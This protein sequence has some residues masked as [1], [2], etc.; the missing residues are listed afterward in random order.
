MGRLLLVSNVIKYINTDTSQRHLF[1]V[2]GTGRLVTVNA[3][4]LNATW[5]APTI[6]TSQTAAPGS[7]ALAACWSFGNIYGMR[8]F[9]GLQ[10]GS[11]SEYMWDFTLN[12]TWAPSET[13]AQADPSS[14]VA[15]TMSGNAT[16]NFVNLYMRDSTTGNLMHKYYDNSTRS[17]V[18]RVG[19]MTGS[20]FD[21][22][23]ISIL[24][25]LLTSRQQ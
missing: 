18:P 25:D 4:D 20:Y 3:S 23:H 1:Y 5:G 24:Q 17:S 8:V 6:I 12:S 10:G 9:V 22:C 15:C 7:P 16:D 2:D 21:I 19:W 11:V 13:F 14:G